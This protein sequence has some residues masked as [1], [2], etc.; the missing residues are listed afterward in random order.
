M[1]RPALQVSHA[2]LIGIEGVSIALALS[3]MVLTSMGRGVE[4]MKRSKTVLATLVVS[5][6]LAGPVLA[7]PYED[8]KAAYKRGDYTTALLLW[9]PL[10]E[11]GNALAQ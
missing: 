5:L 1:R 6:S 11:Q 8:G 9:R 7:G 3:V 10:A 2:L 4:A